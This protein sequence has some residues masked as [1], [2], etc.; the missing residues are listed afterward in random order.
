MFINRN[1]SIPIRIFDVQQIDRQE[2][3]PPS[4]DDKNIEGRENFTSSTHRTR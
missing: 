4:T 3:I 2:I 1:S